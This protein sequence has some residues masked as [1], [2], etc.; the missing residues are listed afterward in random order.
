[1]LF[2]VSYEEY[3]ALEIRIGATK[4]LGDWIPA[5]MGTIRQ[6]I[7]RRGKPFRYVSMIR[8]GREGATGPDAKSLREA[9]RAEPGPQFLRT[10]I[11]SATRIICPLGEIR[12]GCDEGQAF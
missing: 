8:H 4:K 12:S 10:W 1:L 3:H 7:L 2:H 9:D 5:E 11:A 6:E